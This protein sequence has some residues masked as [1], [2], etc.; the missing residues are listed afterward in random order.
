M[1]HATNIVVA[2]VCTLDGAFSVETDLNVPVSCGLPLAVE[3]ATTSSAHVSF[4][5]GESAQ[6]DCD[7]GHTV[8]GKA[9]K[10]VS[11]AV[12]GSSD[13]NFTVQPQD[14]C[15]PVVCSQ[16]LVVAHTLGHSRPW[17]C[18]AALD[19]SE[20]LNIL[21]FQT[22]LM[23]IRFLLTRW[24]L[25][26]YPFLSLE[27]L[28]SMSTIARHSFM[29]SLV[30]GQWTRWQTAGRLERYTNTGHRDETYGFFCR[31]LFSQCPYS[32]SEI[33]LSRPTACWRSTRFFKGVIRAERF[34]A[35]L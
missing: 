27:G 15:M 8:D 24:T 3:F 26:R 33:S 35:P 18:Q 1:E 4:V 19:S 23:Q 17:D 30:C 32:L 5:H 16:A 29:K 9:E 12:M 28:S 14:E 20:R 25:G 11:F 13:G 21:Q 7:R 34:F 2:S 22:P 6:C 10:K 31:D